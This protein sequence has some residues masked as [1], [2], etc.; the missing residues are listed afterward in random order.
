MLQCVSV[1]W[2]LKVPYRIPRKPPGW[3]VE[4]PVNG[5]TPA[6]EVGATIPVDTK[7]ALDPP[8]CR[9]GVISDLGCNLIAPK[10]TRARGGKVVMASPLSKPPPR[11]TFRVSI[12]N[13]HEESMTFNIFQL[14]LHCPWKLELLAAAKLKNEARAVVSNASRELVRPVGLAAR[15]EEYDQ[16]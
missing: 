11:K 6:S 1:R 4:C 2:A 9:F 14:A 12:E 7:M 3:R 8:V 10:T 5:G 16:G 15:K 13:I